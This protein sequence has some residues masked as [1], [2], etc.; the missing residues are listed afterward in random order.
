LG[1]WF[2]LPLTMAMLFASPPGL[3]CLSGLVAVP[4]NL[5]AVTFLSERRASLP[6]KAG[7]SDVFSNCVNRKLI[8][9][10]D[11]RRLRWCGSCDPQGQGVW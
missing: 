10:S 6:P 2:E 4:I 8:A 1:E 9:T 3:Y 7:S 11:D 5:I